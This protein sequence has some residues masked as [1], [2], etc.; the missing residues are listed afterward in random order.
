MRLWHLLVAIAAVGIVV[1]LGR[2]PET[3][4]AIAALVLLAAAGA[5]Y[6]ALAWLAGRLGRLASEEGVQPN[7]WLAAAAL[8]FIGLL[9]PIVA[10][11]SAQVARAFVFLLA[12]LSATRP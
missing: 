5:Q 6:G 1:A 8:P 7:R 3:R 10:I 9:I 2:E 12:S 11:T 4:E